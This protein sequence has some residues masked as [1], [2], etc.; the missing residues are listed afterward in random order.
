MNKDHRFLHGVADFIRAIAGKDKHKSTSAV[1]VAA[2]D[3]SRMGENKQFMTLGGIPVIVRTVEAF[4]KSECIKEII[5]VTRKEDISDVIDLCEKYRFRKVAAVV[6]GGTTRQESVRL[7]FD[8]VSDKSDFVA[9]HDGARCLITPDIIYLIFQLF[10]LQ[11]ALQSVLRFQISIH[12]TLSPRS[13]RRL[14][15]LFCAYR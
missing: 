2:G 10:F 14:L 4:E 1:I 12:L 13:Y 8:E 5:I 6:P 3:S 15:Q 7:G 9:I 11:Y